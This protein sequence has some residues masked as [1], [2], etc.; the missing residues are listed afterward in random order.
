MQNRSLNP[1]EVSDFARVHDHLQRVDNL[2]KD[3]E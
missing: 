2:N 1:G 3:A